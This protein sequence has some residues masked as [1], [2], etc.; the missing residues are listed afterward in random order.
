MPEERDHP[1]VVVLPPLLYGGAFLL[2]LLLRWWRPLPIA[3]P[4]VTLWP[5]IVI[6]V[7]AI[8]IAIVARR[9]MEAAGTNVNPLL[10]TTAIVTTGPFRFSRNPLYVTLTLL[11][12]G[13]T[14]AFDTWWGAILLLPVLA[15]MHFGVILREERYLERKFGEPYRDYRSRVRRYL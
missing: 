14:L 15:I 4:G 3:A 2:A 1:G 10:P 6:S 13:L 5:G 7:L 11:T 12:V 9:T 8:G